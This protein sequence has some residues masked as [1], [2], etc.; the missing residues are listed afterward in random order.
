MKNIALII[1]TVSLFASCSNKKE[2]PQLLEGN[3]SMHTITFE[4]DKPNINLEKDNLKDILVLLHHRKTPLEIKKHFKMNDSIWN[5][6]TNFLFGEGLIKKFNDSSF[7]PTI[8]VLDEE[9]GIA[10]RKFT[11]SLGIEMSGIAI[12]RLSKIKEA[13]Q[14]ISSLKNIPFENLSMLVLGGVVHDFEQLRIYQEQFIKAFVP[15]RGNTNYY[16]CL[17][18]NRRK[19]SNPKFYETLYYNYPAF[20]LVSFASTYYERNI[21]TYSTSELTRDF[22]KPVTESDSVYQFYLLKEIIKLNINPD[23][24]PGENIY[25]G[26]VKTGMVV[27]EKSTI[28][29]LTKE[30]FEKVKTFYSSASQ[31]IINYFE[32]RQ[33]LFVKWY[34]NSPYREETSYKEWTMW[35]YK[36]I[37]AKA[38]DVLA[39]KSYIKTFGGNTAAFIVEK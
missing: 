17:L 9:N 30:D 13:Y 12:D 36:M 16:M 38:V 10:L 33:T 35:V 22:E 20:Y 39:E 27:N 7:I 23:Y 6:R 31:D 21:A 2:I 28:H 4:E 8:F 26:F 11:D 3:F 5:E 34:L 24:K 29:F 15:Q 25:N 1:L 37:T 32:N 14:K 19:E 18:Q